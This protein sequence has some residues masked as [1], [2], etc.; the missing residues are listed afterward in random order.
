MALTGHTFVFVLN[1][2]IFTPFLKGSVF[3]CFKF[4]TTEFSKHITSCVNRQSLTLISLNTVNSPHRRNPKKAAL[5]AAS[6]KELVNI[7]NIPEWSKWQI[8]TK[9]RTCYRQSCTLHM[10]TSLFFLTPFKIVCKHGKGWPDMFSIGLNP[11][12]FK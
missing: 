8:F 5:H 1:N 4:K 2:W 6:K 12:S 3:D 11:F 7:L 10:C 9:N